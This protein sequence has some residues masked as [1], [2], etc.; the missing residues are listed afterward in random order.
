MLGINKSKVSFILRKHVVVFN[1]SEPEAVGVGIVVAGS[2]TMA[3][4]KRSTAKFFQA[5]AR[6]GQSLS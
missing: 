2:A 4:N 1:G 3:L 5:G 6:G